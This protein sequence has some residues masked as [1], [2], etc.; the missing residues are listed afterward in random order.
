M[1]RKEVG[2]MR[3]PTIKDVA[4]RAGVSVGTVSRV[5]NGSKATSP[6]AREAVLAAAQGLGYL[7]NAHARSLRSDHSG[8]IA[9]LVPD[10]RNPFFAELARV[11]EKAALDHGLATLLCNADESAE[12]FDRYVEVIRRQRVDGVAMIPISEAHRAIDRLTTDGIPLVFLDRHMRD[13]AI[14]SIVSEPSAGVSQAVD[15]LLE[16]GHERIG[17]IT[18]PMASS[19]GRER[20]EAYCRA[21][22]ERGITVDG[23]LVATGDFQETSGEEGAGL[24][25][26]RGASA[27]FASDSLMSMGALRTCHARGLRIGVDIDLVGFDDLPVFTLT[28][29]PLT[30]VD[31]PIE[32]IGNRGVDLLTRRMAGEQPD[33]LRLPTRLIVR[34]S[35][36]AGSPSTGTASATPIPMTTRSA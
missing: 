36:R 12:Q 32:E 29:P 4:T 33:D 11:V 30:V 9:L 17:F 7:P 13:T 23:D 27:I 5:L 20:Y 22:S 34:A 25:L 28:D 6:E 14:P 35:T 2:P 3:K 15:H 26:D 24:L 16:C 31:Q 10:I 18:G 1:S 8:T 19:T 21:M